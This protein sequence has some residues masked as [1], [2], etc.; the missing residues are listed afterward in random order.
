MFFKHK[1]LLEELRAT[2]LE[3]RG[4][5]LSVKTIGE[6]NNMRANWAPDEDLTTSWFD[7]RLKL[8]VIPKDRTLSSFEAIVL[9]RVHTL[10]FQ[11]GNVPVWFDPKDFSRVVVDYEADVQQKMQAMA[12]INAHKSDYEVLEHRYDQRLGLV[13]TPIA[14]HLLP[15]EVLSKPGNATLTF[16]TEL[17]SLVHES[18]RAAAAYIFNDA[19]A[20]L[21]TMDS[22]WFRGHDMHVLQSYGSLPALASASDGANTAAAIATAIVSMLKGHMVRTDV[23]VTGRLAPNGAL[24]ATGGMKEKIAAVKQDNCVNRFVVPAADEAEVHQIPEG[25]R[26]GIEFVFAANVAEVVHAALAKKVSK[27]FVSPV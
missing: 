24:L 1:H 15:L 12:Q 18:T 7:V 20:L 2:G 13:W 17:G 4:E 23:A 11:G 19:A 9:T 5:I 14:G 10:K 3:G 22:A 25:A 26:K 21:P 27:N 6:G 16:A 8:K